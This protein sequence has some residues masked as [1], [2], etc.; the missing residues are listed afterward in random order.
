MGEVRQI[1]VTDPET[2]PDYL[3]GAEHV[4]AKDADVTVE[5]MPLARIR[6]GAVVAL[7]C[8]HPRHGCHPR[9]REAYAKVREILGRLRTEQDPGP[10]PKCD[11]TGW[12]KSNSTEA[13]HTMLMALTFGMWRGVGFKPRGLQP[14]SAAD[15][16]GSLLAD[17]TSACASSGP[18]GMA[19][20]ARA[21]LQGIGTGKGEDDGQGN[22]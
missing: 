17:Q 8:D 10:C 9:F 18:D 4:C 19:A 1:E 22:G 15:T 11:G 6:D 12:L 21:I 16:M 13:R 14:G 20:P 2:I 7:G 3:M 5:G